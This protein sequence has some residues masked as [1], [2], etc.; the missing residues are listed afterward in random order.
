LRSPRHTWNECPTL[1]SAQDAI[2]KGARIARHVPPNASARPAVV[3]LAARAWFL[4]GVLTIALYTLHM[5]AMFRELF[6]HQ[7]YADWSMLMAIKR[8]EAASHDQKLRELLHHIL[9]SHRFWLHLIQ[10]L[11]FAVEAENVLPSTLDDIVEL[12]QATQIQ[13]LG[14]IGTLEDS[15]LDRVLE[16]SFFPNRQVPISAALTQVCLHSQGHRSQCATRL[17]M[18]GGE[19]PMVDYILW[20]E[21][22]P[23]PGWT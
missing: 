15:D 21:R 16:S 17:R 10:G 2:S 9:V 19:P 20:I 14:W 7:A 11:P 18:L 8:N 3:R 4:Y 1:F 23:D 6:R 5:I 12:F 22:R 13:E